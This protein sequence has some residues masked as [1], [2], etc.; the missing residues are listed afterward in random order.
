MKCLIVTAELPYPP[1]SGGS[2][3][4]WGLMRGLHASGYQLTVVCCQSGELAPALT[5]IAHVLTIP[6]P[7]KALRQRIAALL[8]STQPDIAVRLFDERVLAALERLL[9][10][11]QFDLVQFEG[12]ETACY[13]PPLRARFPQMTFVFDTFNAEAVMQRTIAQIDQSSPRRWL[14]ALYSHVQSRRIALYESYLCKQADLVI[15]VSDEDKA[16]LCAYGT[17]T[18]IE[19]VPSGI[20]VSD[21]CLP[22]EPR[23]A[24]LLVFTGKMDYRPN[25]DA[26]E[27]L[28]RDILPRIPDTHLQI[29]GQQPTARVQ[30]LANSR[31]EVTGRV[32]EVQPYL[33]RAAVYV[34]PLRMGSGTRLKLLE[35]MA[36]GCAIVATPLAASGLTAEAHRVMRI[37]STAAEFAAE[38]NALLKDAD[39]RAALGLAAREYVQR[40]YDWTAIVPRMIA[41]H[42][43]LKH[44]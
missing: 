19:V 16:H 33:Q 17:S 36:C 41:A 39:M 7:A 3:R 22:T 29:V 1:A 42:E 26:A 9:S 15:A 27:W 2:L 44:E 8:T 20:T 43:R 40:C 13:L 24:N 31:V 38:V 34:A 21:Y 12:I 32:P 30:A 18:P 28:A 35:A 10:S 37:A 11:E 23:E 6:V 14:H 25:T 4:V 5:S